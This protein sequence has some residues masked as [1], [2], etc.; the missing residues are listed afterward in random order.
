MA[1]KKY[2][3]DELRKERETWSQPVPG[4]INSSD[5]AKYL[6]RKQAVDMYIDGIGVSQIQNT[7]G[8]YSS[9]IAQLVKACMNPCE[10][11]SLAGYCGLVRHI[12]QTTIESAPHKR[13]FKHLLEKYPSLTEFIS[14]NYFGDKKYTTEKNMNLKTLHDRFIKECKRIGIMQ[15]EYPFNT[16]NLGYV[17]LCSYIHQLETANI[18]LQMKRLDKDS[19]QKLASTGHGER[20]SSNSLYPFS[21]IQIDG[22]IIDM[23]YT[24]EIQGDD[25]TVS[26]IVAT[27]AWLIAVIDVATRCILGYSVSQEF[28]YDQYDV[29]D[30]IK[31]AIIPKELKELSIRGLSYPSNGGYYSTAFPELKNILFDTIMLDNAKSHLSYFTLGKLTEDLKCSV[32]YGSVATPETRGIVERFFKT[33]E[34]YGFHKLPMTTGSS[35]KDLK[36][37]N[38]EKNALKYEVTYDQITELMDVLIAQYNNT[39]NDGINN[40]TPLE[41]MYQKIYVVGMKPEMADSEMSAS[42]ITKLNL[43]MDERNV[44]GHVKRGKRPYI[45]FMGVEYRSRMLASTELYVGKKIQIIYD[46]RDISTL[47]AYSMDG[48]Y[49]GTLT[50]R[51]EFGTKSHS[52][53]TRKNALRLARE[54]GREH[55]EFD[56]PIEAYMDHLKHESTKSRRAATKADIVRREAGKELPSE[57]KKD[58]NNIIELKNIVDGDK[59]LTSEDI[60]DLTT[61]ELYNVLFEERRN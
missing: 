6:I 24:V 30:A 12:R 1:S 27:R 42:I 23:V 11:G 58:T 29:M 46:P 43:R 37:K 5:Y 61:E 47:E 26:R 28:N 51:G 36:R 55:L 9:R 60:K 59:K 44:R 56:T 19:N 39:P 16:K 4:S 52:V 32:N 14:G 41:C 3:L 15:H 45:Q 25:G 17:S 40:L 49:I 35:P 38:P 22:H 48:C 20:F 33:I 18:G 21:V 13:E 10:D 2:N 50:A 31:D 34:S 8:I 57:E 7:T 53:K 54:R